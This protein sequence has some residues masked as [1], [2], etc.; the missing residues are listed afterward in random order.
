MKLVNQLVIGF[1]PVFE[2]EVTG[3]IPNGGRN[4]LGVAH[5][6]ER[7]TP[8]KALAIVGD[9]EIEESDRER[10]KLNGHSREI[11]DANRFFRAERDVEFV[12]EFGEQVNL[13]IFQFLTVDV[14][15]VFHGD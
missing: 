8:D 13:R 6:R 7:G 15:D 2:E 9:D 4:S 12:R 11:I 14:C 5:A 1:G 3:R 10:F